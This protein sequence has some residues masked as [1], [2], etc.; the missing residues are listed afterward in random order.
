[1]A[2][3]F[4]KFPFRLNGPKRKT[5]LWKFYFWGKW[6]ENIERQPLLFSNLRTDFPKN[7]GR[8]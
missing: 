2:S 7:L 4:E 8:F 1:L 3:W 5:I 6:R